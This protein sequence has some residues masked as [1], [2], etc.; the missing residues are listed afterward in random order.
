M[1]KVTMR[2]W[3]ASLEAMVDKKLV[4]WDKHRKWENGENVHFLW[5]WE[6]VLI[7]LDVFWE[8]GKETV[9]LRFIGPRG[10]QDFMWHGLINKTYRN[11]EHHVAHWA[12]LVFHPPIDPEDIE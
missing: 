1:D 4:K 11:V 9:R 2:D 6:Q 3:L 12:M 5:Q 8:D 10:G 7:K